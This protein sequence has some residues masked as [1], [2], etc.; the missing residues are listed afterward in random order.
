[1]AMN[2]E[3]G[4]LLPKSGVAM[5]MPVVRQCFFFFISS[6]QNVNTGNK[7]NTWC[8]YAPCSENHNCILILENISITLLDKS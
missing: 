2:N 8:Y 6:V 4:R 7:A 5:K 1:M 3:Y